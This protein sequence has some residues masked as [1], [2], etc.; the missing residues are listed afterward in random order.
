M[1]Q[2]ENSYN[3]SEEEFYTYINYLYL[4]SKRGRSFTKTKIE[5]DI[6]YICYEDLFHHLRVMGIKVNFQNCHYDNKINIKINRESLNEIKQFFKPVFRHKLGRSWCEEFNRV[7]YRNRTQ[8][9][10]VCLIIAKSLNISI[11]EL[12][13]KYSASMELMRF[14]TS[15]SSVNNDFSP[16]MD[17]VLSFV[18]IKG[19]EE[20]MKDKFYSMNSWE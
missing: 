17:Q 13:K 19:R 12:L 6:G 15:S 18:T 10:R 2:P 16:T 11:N 3:C 7:I 8:W 9:F 20:F 1:F 5:R 4:R 14:I